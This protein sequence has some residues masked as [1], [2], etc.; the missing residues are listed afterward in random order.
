[1]FWVTESVGRDR[2]EDLLDV[3]SRDREG[4]DQPIFEVKL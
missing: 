2:I 1:V 3:F 4:Q